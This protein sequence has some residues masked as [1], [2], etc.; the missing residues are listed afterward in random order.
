METYVIPPNI[1]IGRRIKNAMAAGN[2]RRTALG[3]VGV[4]I[5]RIV[6]PQDIHITKTNPYQ[7]V[8]NDQQ[9]IDLYGTTLTDI[10][11]AVQVRTTE[12][13]IDDLGDH[14]EFIHYCR[15]YNRAPYIAVV[16]I[17]NRKIYMTRL[18]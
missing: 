1:N 6:R 18:T 4:K 16:D 17:A 11:I 8:N 14:G 5:F 2:D 15:A 9:K 3:I 7:G 13:G 12:T 10:D